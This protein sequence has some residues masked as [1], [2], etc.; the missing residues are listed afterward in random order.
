MGDRICF[1]GFVVSQATPQVVPFLLEL[2]GD[3]TGRARADVLMLISKIYSARQWETA[4]SA[5]WPKS[6]KSYE[7]KVAWEAASRSAISAGAA[8]L[9][10]VTRDPDPVIANLAR[11]LLSAL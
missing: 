6:V 8:V 7:K 10:G 5:A 9:D 1:L 2:V 11:E 4:A 3:S